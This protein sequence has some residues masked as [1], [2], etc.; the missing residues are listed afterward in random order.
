MGGSLERQQGLRQNFNATGEA[1][2]GCHGVC[3]PYIIVD[4]LMGMPVFASLRF[5][6]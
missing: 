5:A 1:R 2:T 4:S 6:D 3:G